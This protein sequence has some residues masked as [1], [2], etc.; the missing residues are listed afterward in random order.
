MKSTIKETVSDVYQ[1]TEDGNLSG[2]SKEILKL[3]FLDNKITA[4]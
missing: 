3:D 1:M 4:I 2:N